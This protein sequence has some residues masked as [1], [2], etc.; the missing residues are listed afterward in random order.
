MTLHIVSASPHAG[1]AFHDCL[2]VLVP[3]DALLLTGD[4]VYALLPG[5]APALSLA[6][7][8]DSVGI[9]ALRDDCTQR[10]I[11]ELPAGVGVID[12]A[13]F[14]ALACTHPRSVSWF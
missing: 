12:Y 9:H 5:T 8:A 2:R 13:D 4:A 14:V 1:A 7:M 6:G 3:G 11:G 10:G